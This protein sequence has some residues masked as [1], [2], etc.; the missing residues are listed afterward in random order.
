MRFTKWVGDRQEHC[1]HTVGYKQ[2]TLFTFS[3]NPD[4][5]KKKPAGKK[6][7]T[8]VRFRC[9]SAD[10]AAF[11]QA[12]EREGFGGNVSAWLLYHLRRIAQ[13]KN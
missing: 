7:D 4:M 13:G 10:L 9:R 6:S 8:T 2:P 5:A 12:A 3:Y 1:S 11:K